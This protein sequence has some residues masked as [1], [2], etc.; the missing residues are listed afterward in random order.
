[1]NKKLNIILILILFFTTSC[2]KKKFDKAV[3]N[4]DFVDDKIT[5]EN[6]NEMLDDLLNNYEL[7]GKSISEIENILGK[8]DEHSFSDSTNLIEIPV[9]V[10][11]R[12][13]DPYKYKNLYL[14]YNSKK[15]IDS[16]YVTESTVD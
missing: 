7:K 14:R 3:W 6:R 11:W 4:S 12:G 2:I 5:Y 8:L 13:I 15:I 1:M 10:K 16:V 9:L